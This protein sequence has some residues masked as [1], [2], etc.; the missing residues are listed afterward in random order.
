MLSLKKTR[1]NDCILCNGRE[2]RDEDEES[3]IDRWI[4]MNNPT[5]AT[6]SACQ[7]HRLLYF[8]GHDQ[9]LKDSS[10]RNKKLRNKDFQGEKGGERTV[11]FSIAMIDANSLGIIFSE[12]HFDEEFD[13]VLLLDRKR[14]RSF[15]FNFFWWSKLSKSIK[16]FGDGDTIAAWI[17]AGDDIMLSNIKA[18]IMS[19]LVPI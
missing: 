1:D 18:F 14:R 10:L 11:T 17:T 9:R 4:G 2:K 8:L 5:E 6:T 3:K 15:Q 19:E 13:E 7:S 16:N 12:R